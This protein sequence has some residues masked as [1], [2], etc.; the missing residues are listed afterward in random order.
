METKGPKAT[1]SQES[2]EEIPGIKS[3][4]ISCAPRQVDVSFM[5]LGALPALEEQPSQQIQGQRSWSGTPDIGQ[6]VT[7]N[8]LT[9]HEKV[10]LNHISRQRSSQETI[11]M[12]QRLWPNRHEAFQDSCSHTGSKF[13][14]AKRFPGPLL[15][16]LLI[17]NLFLKRTS[18]CS[19]TWQGWLV[20]HQGIWST[21]SRYA[22][23]AKKEIPSQGSHSLVFL[24]MWYHVNGSCQRD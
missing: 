13:T 20:I 3:L 6:Q 8:C 21:H 4:G 12:I 9:G 18:T 16:H 2:T 14:A 5:V 10:E 22:A 1:P 11:Q 23:T 24:L 17:S 19:Q 15:Y 7:N